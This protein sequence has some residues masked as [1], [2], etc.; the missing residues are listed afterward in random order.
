MNGRIVIEDLAM[1]CYVD[2]RGL[3]GRE[4][5]VC[6]AP[7]RSRAGVLDVANPLWRVY[8]FEVTVVVRPYYSSLTCE[9]A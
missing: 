2:G 1:N 8:L 9:T 3:K 4:F 5:E 6:F 7:S